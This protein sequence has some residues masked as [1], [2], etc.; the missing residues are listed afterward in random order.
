MQP[1][2]ATEPASRPPKA[3]WKR[4]RMPILVLGITIL[5]L[6]FLN[7]DHRLMQGGQPFQASAAS[8]RVVDLVL[9]DATNLAPV[10]ADV[11]VAGVQATPLGGGRYVA[12]L[13]EGQAASEIQAPGYRPLALPAGKDFTQPLRMVPDVVE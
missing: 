11:S 6:L 12:Q 10:D 7:H 2:S 8:A 9:V 13:A 3:F 5:A 4:W 1:D